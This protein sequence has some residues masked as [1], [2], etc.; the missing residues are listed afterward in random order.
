MAKALLIQVQHAGHLFDGGSWCLELS[1]AK[2]A[3]SV[4]LHQMAQF[5]ANGLIAMGDFPTVFP[6][7][8]IDFIRMGLDG[9]CT[10]S[11]VYNF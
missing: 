9:F 11:W 8:F 4:F 3:I 1:D 10:Q 2:H 6:D 7:K 5:L